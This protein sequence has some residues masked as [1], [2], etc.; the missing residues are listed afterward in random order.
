[1]KRSGLKRKKPMKRGKPLKRGTPGRPR[2]KI[3]SPYGTKVGK[4]LTC[5]REIAIANGQAFKQ[6]ARAQRCCAV[7]GSTGPWEAHHVIEKKYLVANGLPVFC[8]ENSLRLC[9]EPCHGRHTRA[10]QRVALTA[11]TD[12]NIRYAFYLLD[13]AAYY[14]LTDHYA[15]TDSR[16]DAMKEEYDRDD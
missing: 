4:S 10:S 8:T 1:M 16:V 2:H 5:Q 3:N 6:E 13:G 11:L 7:C 15:G 12:R 14:Y 9:K